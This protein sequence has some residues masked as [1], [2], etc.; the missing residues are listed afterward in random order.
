MTTRPVATY[1][2]FSFK[3]Q[4]KLSFLILSEDFKVK[5]FGADLNVEGESHL[6]VLMPFRTQRNRALVLQ[7]FLSVT[8][9]QRGN[10]F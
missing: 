9:T 7:L 8:S 2:E 4:Q 1:H 10:V 5:C 3:I 6:I